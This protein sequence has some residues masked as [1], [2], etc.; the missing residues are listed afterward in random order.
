MLGAYAA[1]ITTTELGSFWPSLITAPLLVGA[2]ALVVESGLMRRLYQRPL[3][4]IL[5]T[6]GLAIVL[7]QGVEAVAGPDF[8]NVPNPLPGSAA[9][10]GVEYP[11]Y[12]LA[13]IALTLVIIVGLYVLQRTTRAGLVARAVILNPPLAGTLGINVRRVYQATFALGSALAGLAGALLAPTVNVF[14]EMGPPFVVNAFLAV[15]VGGSGSMPG[16]VSACLLLG[17]VQSTLSRY[18]SPVAGTVG[19]LVVAVLTL[20][21]LPHGLT[22]T[23][24]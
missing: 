14:P 2:M 16:L 3:E 8:R 19:F 9:V 11:R 6:W 13:V 17:V 23:T 12:R 21:F 10:L 1:L 22:R 4:T 20:R 24:S 5:A 7:R 15:L 18:E